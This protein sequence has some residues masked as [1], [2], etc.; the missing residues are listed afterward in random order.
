MESLACG[1]REQGGQSPLVG[2]TWPALGIGLD[3]VSFRP[4][5]SSSRE[6]SKQEKE[7]ERRREG[8]RTAAG[9]AMLGAPRRHPGDCR[10]EVASERDGGL[11][12]TSRGGARRVGGEG[13]VAERS[14][15][16]LG[17]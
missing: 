1:T 14:V 3:A 17:K 9:G 2:T 8:E 10:G 13:G 7:R 16:A 6:S 4:S 15:R 12:S 5:S 11:G